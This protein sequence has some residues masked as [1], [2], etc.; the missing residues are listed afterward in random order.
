MTRS[1]ILVLSLLLA[2]QSTIGQDYDANPYLNNGYANDVNA[3][4]SDQERANSIDMAKNV[5]LNHAIS[6]RAAA[7][8]GPAYLPPNEKQSLICSG[9]DVCVPKNA[10]QN[11]YFSQKTASRNT[12]VSSAISMRVT[13][14]YFLEL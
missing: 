13:T 2:V 4:I 10:C 3:F 9:Q 1:R 7:F 5:F 6:H 8:S 14:I 12:Q 11:G